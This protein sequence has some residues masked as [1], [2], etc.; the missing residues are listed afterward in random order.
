MS[1]WSGLNWLRLGFGG[2]FSD[3][4]ELWG[5]ITEF[6]SNMWSLAPGI[7]GLNRYISSW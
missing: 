4:E 5:L 3:C 6:H 1:M 7:I 2:V